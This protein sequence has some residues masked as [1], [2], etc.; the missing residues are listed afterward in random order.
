MEPAAPAALLVYF[1]GGG[2]VTGDL[3]TSD[4]VCRILAHHSGAQVLSVDYRLAPEHPFPD[5]I[6]DAYTAFRYAVE[7]AESFDVDP[8]LIAVGGDS[9]G[10]NLA[11]VVCHLAR[12]DGGVLPAFQL[13]LVPAVD[14]VS[15]QRSKALFAEGFQL[16][17]TMADW[18]ISLYL[19]SSADPYDPRVSPLLAPDL[20]GLP[21]AY[22][23]T[24]GFDMLRDQG[25]E[26]AVRLAAAGVPVVHRSHSGFIHPFAVM[27][28]FSKAATA[29]LIETA[30]GLRAGIAMTAQPTADRRPTA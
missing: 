5:P 19:G 24:A 18:W 14:L 30:G 16:T 12:R 13:L 15:E 29:A 7:N 20:S 27:T 11:A 28:G 25:A 9:A 26:Y 23:A 22:I 21:P 17:R 1:H 10:A 4:N 8:E 6:D 2:W 3:E